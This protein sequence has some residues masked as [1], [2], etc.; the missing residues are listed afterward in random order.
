[1][2]TPM[3]SNVGTRKPALSPRRTL[4]ALIN[5]EVRTNLCRSE[6]EQN[7]FP[8]TYIFDG[9]LGGMPVSLNYASS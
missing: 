8:R 4:L 5:R 3:N 9:Q 7:Y 2:V 1:M 6:F